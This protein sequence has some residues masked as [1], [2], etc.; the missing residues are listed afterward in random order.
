VTDDFPATLDRLRDEIDEGD[1]TRGVQA[2]VEVGGRR[3]LDVALGDAGTGATMTSDH[4]LRVYCTGKPILALAVAQ[5][6]D[7]GLLDLDAPLAHQL[8]DCRPLEGGVT[9]RHVLTHTG[10]LHQP[11]GVA[12]EMIPPARR[13]Q[14]IEQTRRAGPFRIGVDAAYS[15]YAGWQVMGWVVEQVSGEALRAH[16][17]RRV[18]DPMGLTN[19]WIGMTPDDYVAVLPRLGV[20]HEMRQGSSLPMLFERTER[21][22]TETNP[23]HGCYASAGDLARFYSGVLAG[24]DGCGVEELPSPPTLELFTS[25]ARPPVPD[26]VLERV[27]SYGLGFMTPLREHAFGEQCSD[28]AFGHSGNIGSSF[29]FADPEHALTVG[30]VFNGL[31]GHEAAFL[32]RRALVGAVYADLDDQVRARAQEQA[33]NERP[34]PEPTRG[35]LLGR[36][37]SRR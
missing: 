24:L 1:F 17:R 32:R 21:V 13:R 30:I 4:V 31:V 5:L 36:F 11:S 22:C 15:E 23:S 26:A 19:T 29:A 14:L 3:V 34:A 9:L 8:P 35:G 10:G 25:V 7:D 37:R 12:M 33:G 20:N 6:V 16:L 27:C 18:L 2:V 28:R